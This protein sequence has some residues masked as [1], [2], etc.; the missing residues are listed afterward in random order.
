MINHY[1]TTTLFAAL[2]AASGKVIGKYS[3]NHKAEDYVEFLKILDKKAP[4]KKILHIMADNYSSHKAP[5]GKE[6]RFVELFIPT[7]SSWLNMIE[8]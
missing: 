3:K 4:K 1:G 7:Y 5:L 8:R 2:N 6:N